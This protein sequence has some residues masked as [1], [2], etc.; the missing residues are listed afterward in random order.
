[1]EIQPGDGSKPPL[2]LIHAEGGHVLM[3]R[4]LAKNL[5]SDWTVYGIQ[6]RGL[7]GSTQ[8]SD[9]IEEMA[10]RYISEIRQ[11]QP[12]GPYYLGGW[13]LGGTIGYEM[14][15]QLEAEGE[16]VAWLGMVQARHTNYW[17]SRDDAFAL[18]RFAWRAADRVS[19]ESDTVSEMKGRTKLRYVVERVRRFIVRQWARVPIGRERTALVTE[20]AAA[21]TCSR[22][23]LSAYWAYDPDSY[24]GRIA[25]VRSSHQPHGIEPDPTLGWGP[26]LKGDVEL[27]EV[28]SHHGNIIHGERGVVV[29]DILRSSITSAFAL[30]SREVGADDSR[31]TVGST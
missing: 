31:S 23:H 30:E 22:A 3:Y 7:D 19:F 14:A 1:V 16:R 2:F 13:C 24:D 27:Y 11:V 4:D 15:K 10:G 21:D 5:G 25:L 17:K 28:E 12:R 6:S 29:A 26:L 20:L 8:P 9:A 18:K